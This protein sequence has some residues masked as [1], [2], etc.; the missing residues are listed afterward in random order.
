MD[1]F[2]SGYSSLSMLGQMSLDILKLD[3][4]FLRNELQK[5]VEL[6]LLNDVINMAHRMHLAV[7]AEGVETRDQ[8]NRLQV[9]GCDCAQGF[10][11]AKPIPVEEFEILL[12]S[13]ENQGLNTSEPRI[14]K[15]VPCLLVVDEDVDFCER[16]KSFFEEGYKVITTS[17]PLQAASI[18]SEYGSERISMMLLSVELPNAGTEV[19]LQKIQEHAGFLK[20]PVIG[21]V[22][23]TE[24]FD[25]LNLA[26][27][28]D[29]LYHK[30]F[31]FL[32]LQR[33]IDR[34]I[35]VMTFQ[36]WSCILQDE[37]NRDYLTALLNR[38]GL[39]EAMGS[40]RKQDLP[41]AVCMFD[42]DDLKVIN[43]TFGHEMGDHMLRSFAELLKKQT[44]VSDIR[45]RYGGDE[46]VVILKSIN[47]TNAAL[48]KCKEICR[49][50]GQGSSSCS[51][52]VAFCDCNEVPSSIL[53]NRADEALYQVK[54]NGKR[55]CNLWK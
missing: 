53:I 22:S 4:M 40:L 30:V 34:L 31:P 50:F 9:M 42:V 47:D 36:K 14:D 27:H 35:D 28:L 18:V 46:F 21:M 43:D 19:L 6:S 11:F 24:P 26:E 55:N 29:D 51:C 15:Y 54:K 49:L 25:N 45:C 41:L 12:Q 3:M 23:S 17:D 16:F 13:E 39:Q 48:N 2:G 8:K 37:T 10:F 38:R 7:V 52:G 20:F 33:S 5:P 44:R 1:D 32:E